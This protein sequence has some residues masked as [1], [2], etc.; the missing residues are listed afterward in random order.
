[1]TTSALAELRSQVRGRVLLTGDDDFD[2][3]RQPWNLAVQQPVSAVVEA[4]DADDVSAVVRY[5]AAAGLVVAPQPGG[6]GASG[7]VEGVILLRT[8]KLDE[9]HVDA[10]ARTARVGAGV[11][12][13]Q[14]Q[15]VAGPLG[16]T[17]LPGS[18][19]LVSVVGYTLGGGLSWF[20]R[21]YGWAA[22][23]VTAFEV[24]T[25]DGTQTRVTADSDA[26]LF[27]ALRGG[28]G[29]YA[30]VTAIEYDLHPAPA[31]FGGR[32]VWH[33]SQA[34]RVLEAFRKITSTAPDELTAWINFLQIPNG[35]SLVTVDSTFLGEEAEGRALLGALDAIEGANT[36]TRGML[37]VAELGEITGEP[38]EPGPSATRAELLTDLDDK[39]AAALLAEP[40]DPLFGVHIRHLGGAF[41]TPTEN[42]QG[43]LTEPYTLSMFGLPFTPERGA[44]IAARQEALVQSVAPYISGRKPYT[45]LSPGDTAAAAFKPDALARLQQV[46]RDRDPRGVFRS[47]FP[48]LG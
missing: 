42:P 15:A 25:A 32:V 30:L 29:D 31:L 36:D 19:P 35:P 9:L 4:A 26:E 24:V 18:S 43:P 3:A 16:L 23:S 5:A 44:E 45:Y 33:G 6:R 38:T 20:G 46:K 10:A 34:P 21:K 37:P 28:G 8:G 40:V 7:D 17:G 14:V 47:N 27:W 22:D 12:G 1:M 13:G 41:A 11:L 48:V 2:Q 39:V